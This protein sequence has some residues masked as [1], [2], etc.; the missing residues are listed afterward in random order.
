M[1]ETHVELCAY[2][3]ISVT[4]I[5]DTILWIEVHKCPTSMDVDKLW[6]VV[7]TFIRNRTLHLTSDV[8]TRCNLNSQGAGVVECANASQPDLEIHVE[9]TRPID[10]LHPPTMMHII[11]LFMSE[12][13][14]RIKSV[15]IYAHN[16][17]AESMDNVTSIF[18]MIVPG[19][20][21]RFSKL[22]FATRKHSSS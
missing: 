7:S 21:V 12:R 10:A 1:S 16:I 13:M 2:D 15:V 11:K 20:R 17:C 6:T 4:L 3:W 18:G 9:I 8:N 14:P 5:D 22:T 19:L